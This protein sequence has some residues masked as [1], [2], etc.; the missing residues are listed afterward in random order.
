[1]GYIKISMQVTGSEEAERLIA[2]L[3]ELSVEGFEEKESSLEAFLDESVYDKER[4]AQL[5]NDNRIEFSEERIDTI[6][7]NEAW[8]S[9]YDPVTVLHPHTGQTF[10]HIRASFHAIDPDA[11]HG[12]L[13]NPKM[14]FGT[15]H[16][17][18]TCLMAE[19]LALTPLAGRSVLDFGTGTGILAI[20]AEKLGASGIMAIDND[21]WSIENAGENA[22]LNECERIVF[23]QTD[24]VIGDKRYDV[25]LANINLNVICENFSSLINSMKS[26]GELIFSGILNSDEK[27]LTELAIKNS[28]E[29]VNISRKGEWSLIHCKS[30]PK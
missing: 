2:L 8:E 20:L 6:N 13:I 18:T 16:H 10:A 7:W 21:S 17:A 11:L 30:I 22:T 26:S 1:M 9:N 29:I 12:I 28:L 3:H 5:L 24:K 25:I 23:Q 4:I 27:I 14:S 19:E 15:G